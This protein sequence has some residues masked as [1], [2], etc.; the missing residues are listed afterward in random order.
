MDL[1]IAPAA[2]SADAIAASAILTEV[3]AESSIS[4]VPVV[5][6]NKETALDNAELDTLPTV[7]IV[8]S[9]VSAMLAEAFMSASTIVP[10]VISEDSI[11]WPKYDVATGNVDEVWL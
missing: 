9:L 7:A 2:R 5:W 10:S 6:P 1:I 11:V 4:L 3:I 8:A